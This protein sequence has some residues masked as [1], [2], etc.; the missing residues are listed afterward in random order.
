MVIADEEIN[1]SL[2]MLV[3]QVVVRGTICQREKEV[4]KAKAKAKENPKGKGL[5][6]GHKKERRWWFKRKLLLIKTE[7]RKA[8]H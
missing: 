4:E 1:V 2:N 7:W 3:H 5:A 6:I 8:L